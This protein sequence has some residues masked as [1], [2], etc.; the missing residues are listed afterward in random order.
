MRTVRIP[1]EALAV[2]SSCTVVERKIGTGVSLPFGQLDRKLYLKVNEVLNDVGGQWNRKE[3]VH[4]FPGLGPQQVLE[5][6]DDVILSGEIAPLRKNGFF[7]TPVVIADLM[8]DRLELYKD[9]CIL[10]PEFGTGRLI[11]ACL[12]AGAVDIIGMEINEKLY[13]PTKTAL[14]KAWPNAAIMLIHGDF[15]DPKFQDPESFDRIIMNP[16]FENLQD[17]R[18]IMRAWTVL[19]PGGRLISVAGAGVTFRREQDACLLRNL[20]DDYGKLEE[21]PENSFR[22][23]GTD[24]NTVLVT[25]NKPRFYGKVKN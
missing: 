5:K 13:G 18:H 14:Y 25:L 23:S 7:P 11:E 12:R 21:L 6:L 22:E 3:G 17:V 24:V 15:M 19:K 16:P 10:D 20:I 1:D 8:A 4:V 9:H 2:L